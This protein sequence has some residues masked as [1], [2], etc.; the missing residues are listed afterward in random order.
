MA[1]NLNPK[2]PTPPTDIA[3]LAAALARPFDPSEIHW[4]PQTVSGNR[5]LVV[6]F[7]DAR[8]IQDRLD[9]V[10]GV[11]NWQDHYEPLPDGSVVC[12]LQI[13]VGDEWITKQDVGGPSE[14]PDEGD[15]RKAAF[16]DALKRAAVKFGI[17]RYLYRLKPQWVDYDPAK[18]RIVGT[19]RVVVEDKAPAG[20]RATSAAAARPAPC[21]AP[22]VEQAS[23][24]PI[25]KISPAQAAPAGKISPDQAAPNGL[26]RTGE[27]LQRRLARKD[28]QLAAEKLCQPGELVQFVVAQGVKQ[29]LAPEL[30][31]W[32]S[33]AIQLAIEAVKTFEAARRQPLDQAA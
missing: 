32:T 3:A 21:P 24:T 9:E 5:A 1:K 30:A 8:L 18:R 6:A 19:P 22:E 17:G 10:V 31:Q 7:V 16:S 13:R 14:Q 23:A 11:L 26:P 4:K 12:R 15:R 29:G 27:E 2:S 28:A 20:T 25:G 33:D